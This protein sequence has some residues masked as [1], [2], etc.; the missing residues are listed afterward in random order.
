MGKRH[1]R[2]F[3]KE[4]KTEAVRLATTGERTVAEVAV[5]LGVDQ[6]LLSKWIAASRDE[7]TD[8]FRGHGKRTALEE[9]VWRLKLKNKQLEQEL[10]FL[11]KVSRYFAKD[12][13]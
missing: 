1:R 2:I 9:E 7:G 8:A 3:D 11:K 5:S 12:P 6:S 13:R 4:F 10:E